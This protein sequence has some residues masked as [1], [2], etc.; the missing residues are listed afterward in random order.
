MV[1]VILVVPG[2]RP[3]DNPRLGGDSTRTAGAPEMAQDSLA[4]GHAAKGSG[5]TRVGSIVG[6]AWVP[7]GWAS[8]GTTFEIQFGSHRT[9]GTVA[10]HPFYDPEG[11]RLRS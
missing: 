7:A 4:A 2:C 9:T 6:L 3:R 1:V 11:Q 5:F 10:M 8:D